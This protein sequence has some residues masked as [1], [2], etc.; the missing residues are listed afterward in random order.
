MHVSVKLLSK[1]WLSHIVG[2]RP[3][4]SKRAYTQVKS[5]FNPLKYI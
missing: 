4:V 1:F 5:Y 2:C 3:V